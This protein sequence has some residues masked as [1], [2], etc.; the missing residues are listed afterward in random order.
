[1]A[2]LL[3]EFR[4]MKL[5]YSLLFMAVLAVGAVAY[6][7][8]QSQ[9][10]PP[11]QKQQP[12]DAPKTSITGCL[13][14]GATDG[15][16]VIAD[17]TSGEKVPFNG[18]SQLDQYVNQTVRLTGTVTGEGTGKVFRPEAIAQVSPSCAKAQ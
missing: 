16:Y 18:P 8:D 10:A 4:P 17:Q 14:K 2:Q 6:A 11:Q 12:S 5:L 1:M 7:Q 9:T 3:L 13:T 15:N